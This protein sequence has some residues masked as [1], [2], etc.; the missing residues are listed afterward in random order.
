MVGWTARR[1]IA[2]AA[3]ILAACNFNSG[4]LGNGSAATLGGGSSGDASDSSDASG[5]PDGSAGT[6]S[7]GSD[8]TSS[9]S[10]TGNPTSASTTDQPPGSTGEA[11]GGPMLVFTEAPTHDFGAVEVATATGKVDLTV[12]NE[13][14]EAATAVKIVEPTAPFELADTSCGETLDPGASCT[15]GV[16]YTPNDLGPQTQMLTVQY[17]TAQEAS[18]ELAGMGIGATGNLLANPGAE[19]AGKPPP[20]WTIIAGPNWSATTVQVTAYEGQRVFYCG[21][22]GI[23]QTELRQ[24]IDLAKYQPLQGL[25]TLRIEY[26]GRARTWSYGED[27]YRVRV[28]FEDAAGDQ[29]G[30]S[31]VNSNWIT[32]NYWVEET[33]SANI[34]AN[35]AAV[36]V[37][38][39]CVWLDGDTCDS[40]FDAQFLQVTF[41]P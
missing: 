7:A 12:T 21:N 31:V 24:T 26:R 2:A 30:S 16:G 22:S 11:S 25:G 35:A 38:L 29:I 23:S 5:P 19:Q 34:P 15:V 32:S 39:E 27:G 40:L 4:G 33:G 36:R 13:G 10:T 14:D 17:D 1:D 9:E 3:L 41:S 8:G 6:T 37:R 28:S 18:I 20:G